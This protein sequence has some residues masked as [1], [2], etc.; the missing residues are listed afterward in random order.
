MMITQY[1]QNEGYH[2][3]VA[4][5]Y[6][7]STVKSNELQVRKQR[8]LYVVQILLEIVSGDVGDSIATL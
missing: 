6:D 8:I 5:I 7:E 4:A 1:L 2:T 3:S